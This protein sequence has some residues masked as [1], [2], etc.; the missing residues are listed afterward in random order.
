MVEWSDA[1]RNNCMPGVMM[2][3]DDEDDNDDDMRVSSRILPVGSVMPGGPRHTQ[4]LLPAVVLAHALLYLFALFAC[5]STVG[6]FSLNS[7][8]NEF[9]RALNK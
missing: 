6:I 1:R 8:L 5:C 2:D 9:M 4:L 3:D 7:F